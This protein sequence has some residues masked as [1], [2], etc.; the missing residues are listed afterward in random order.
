MNKNINIS[1]HNTE[2]QGSCNWNSEDYYLVHDFPIQGRLRVIKSPC[3]KRVPANFNL[4]QWE[5]MKEQL[6]S[7]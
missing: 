1:Y 7:S 5:V 3:L 6:P 2:D 4:C